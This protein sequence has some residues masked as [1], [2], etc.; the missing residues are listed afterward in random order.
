MPTSIEASRAYRLAVFYRDR[1]ALELDR[2]ARIALIQR[3]MQQ[4]QARRDAAWEAH[5]AACK[6]CR[7]GLCM[8]QFSVPREFKV[9]EEL[10]SLLSW[11]ET[12]VEYAEKARTHPVN[13]RKHK[14]GFCAYWQN[15]RARRIELSGGR[16]E[17]CG[18]PATDCHHLH[19]NTLGF[20]EL[21]DVRMLC[22]SCHRARHGHG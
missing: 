22:R 7:T 9:I 19:Y 12:D 3:E 8:K 15:L 5:K 2:A 13:Y 21:D 10:R 1:A 17:D 20:E 16:C 18:E 11:E 14:D 6:D 4:L